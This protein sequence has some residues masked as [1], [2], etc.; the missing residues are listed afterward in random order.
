MD[1]PL[2]YCIECEAPTGRAGVGEDSL[3]AENGDGPFCEDCYAL[4][5]NEQKEESHE[6]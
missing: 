2:E 6:G 5:T 3:Y 4:L 1:R